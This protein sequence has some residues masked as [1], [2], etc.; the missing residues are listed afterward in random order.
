MTIDVND[1]ATGVHGIRRET[2]TWD[3]FLDA[4]PSLA[5]VAGD[6]AA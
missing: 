2:L 1:A 3:P 4:A 6:D 5:A